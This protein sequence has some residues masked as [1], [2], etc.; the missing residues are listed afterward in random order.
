MKRFT[1]IILAVALAMCLIGGVL[2][3]VGIYSG[4]RNYLESSY[5]DSSSKD[6]YKI[7]SM[8]KTKIDNFNS[9]DVDLSNCD[10]TMKPSEDNHFYLS[11]Q[12]YGKK[13]AN[14]FSYEVKD[15]TLSMKEVS[16]YHYVHID[17]SFLTRLFLNSGSLDSIFNMQNKATIY[18][19]EGTS[20]EEASV[21]IDDGDLYAEG[22]NCKN[23][24]FELSYG[25]FTL[26]NMT[27]ETGTINMDD[28]DLNITDVN[29]QNFNFHIAY[30]DAVL[31]DS[32]LNQ[33]TVEMNDGDF[34]LDNTTLT[35]E[36][37]F[38]ISYG[39]AEIR[40][41]ENQLRSL[42]LHFTTDYG[43]ITLPKKEISM[44]GTLSHYN[45]DDLV[46]YDRTGSNPDAVLTIECNDGDIIIK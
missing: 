39:D 43:D 40:M 45:D 24:Q 36:S 46:Q 20:L 41:D 38:Q 25:D 1:K 4:G 32:T 37:N 26:K 29:A 22:L 10:V 23:I 35:G 31:K 15:N 16:D 27:F 11:Y 3:L 6:G 8:D 34:C 17:T 19:P 2:L 30:G 14:P 13:T 44:K 18:V 9:V 28:G 33:T 21:S 12:V 7:Y 42:T 5:L